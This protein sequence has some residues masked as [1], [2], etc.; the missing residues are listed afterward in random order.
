MASFEAIVLSDQKR[1]CGP[2]IAGV[3]VFVH[4]LAALAGL[5][6]VLRA[7]LLTL[8]LARLR[9]TLLAAAL[10]R[11]LIAALAGLVS[12]LLRGL[13][14]TLLTAAFLPVRPAGHI[15]L[16]ALILAL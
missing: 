6:L 4:E 1:L 9:T 14:A 7:G 16:S 12:A 5:L 13:T 3:V 11:G 8:V 2:A 15:L 10:L